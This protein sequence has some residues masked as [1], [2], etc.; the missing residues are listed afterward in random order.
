MS[1]QPSLYEEHQIQITEPDE[2]ET[3]EHALLQLNR[4]Y[5]ANQI[6]KGRLLER[7]DQLLTRKKELRRRA[8]KDYLDDFLPPITFFSI[9]KGLQTPEQQ[10]AEKKHT[11]EI[12]IK[13]VR[14]G[15]PISTR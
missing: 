9:E 3:V 12:T 13:R 14:L 5:A 15:C 7:R 11:I 6:D 2:L 1:A 8:A 10:R 4:A